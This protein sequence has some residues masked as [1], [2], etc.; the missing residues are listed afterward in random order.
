[1]PII[2]MHSRD[3]LLTRAISLKAL[4]IIILIFIPFLLSGITFSQATTVERTNPEEQHV[5]SNNPVFIAGDFQYFDLTL[6]VDEEKIC[7]IAYSGDSI[8]DPYDRSVENYYKWEYDQGTWNDLSDHDSLYIKPSK[9][10][11]ENNTYFFHIG[12]DHKANPGHWTI[13][14]IVDEKEVSSTP[15]IV[16]ISSF[17]FFLYAI[18]GVFEP[19]VGD[20]KYLVDLDFI[21]SDRKRIMAELEKNVDILVDEVLSKNNLPSKK[22]KAVDDILDLSPFNSKWLTQDELVKS[23]VTTYPR[24]RLKEVQTNKLNSFFIDEKG[25]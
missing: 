23:T 14:V 22:E 10:S 15:S 3:G 17:S 16:M 24:G 5:S 11:K 8:P 13:K 2:R 25:N 6:T 19:T 7:I 9:C 12:I 20:K 18:I 21:C 1:M 4:A